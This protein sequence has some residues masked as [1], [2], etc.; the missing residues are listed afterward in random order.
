MHLD[1]YKNSDIGQGDFEN[2]SVDKDV[3]NLRQLFTILNYD[4]IPQIQTDKIKDH[5]TE[6]EIIA[7]L[8]DDIPHQLLDDKNELKYDGLIVCITG[9]GIDKNIITSDWKAI[10]KSVIHR[11][12]SVNNPKL[13]DIPRIFLIDT[14]DGDGERKNDQFKGHFKFE[15][16]RVVEDA[17][18]N[19]NNDDVSKYV[20]LSDI[21][22]ANEWNI[23]NNNPDYKLV[24]IRAANVGYQAKY[25]D[26]FG[27]YLLYEFAE[28]MK[29]NVLNNDG[30]NNKSETLGEIFDAIHDDLHSKGKQ[31]IHSVF[32]NETKNIILK[33]NENKKRERKQ[34]AVMKIDE[35]IKSKENEENEYRKNTNSYQYLI[36]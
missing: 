32:N 15:L 14:C 13:R 2:I 10:Q 23:S 36:K 24:E 20:G 31:L 12:I 18:G 21:Q 7:F 11:I 1:D 34:R 4:I 6:K 25:N 33:R 26:K 27:S 29:Q 16:M 22:K 5:W 8:K 9:H 30:D 17:K 3:D 35:L 28:R 19:K